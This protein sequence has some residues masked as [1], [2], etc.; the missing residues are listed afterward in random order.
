VTPRKKSKKSS[1]R[2]EPAAPQAAGS[3]SHSIPDPQAILAALEERGVPTS[4]AALAK[5]FNLRDDK[6][7]KGLTKQL[8]QM[9][10]R[11]QLLQNRRDEYCLLQK[12]DAITGKVSAH[13]DGFGFLIR[14]G[15]G[16]D[17]FLPPH[18]MS[19]I[20]DGDRVAVRLSGTDRKGRPKGELVEILERGK[21]TA[22][23]RFCSE[24]GVS[25]VVETTRAQ[26]HYLVAPVDT[27]G[28]KDGEMVKIEI[29]AYPTNRREAQGK[30]V[31]VLG[32]PDDPGMLT[33]MAIES[34]GLRTG[35]SKKTREAAD[36]WGAEVREAD[37]AGRVDLRKVP[38]VTIDGADAR[39]FD[40]AVYAEPASQ[41]KDK[42]W[43]LLVAIA[44]VSHYVQRDDA[45]DTEARKRGTSTYFPDRVVPMLPEKLSNGLC[46][47]N[48]DVD[49]L[50]LVCEMHVS[51]SGK[52]EKSKFFKGVMRSH[53]RLTYSQVNEV[54]GERDPQARKEHAAL[55]PQLEH[56]YELFK[57]FEKARS[58]RGALDLELPEVRITMGADNHSVE[59]VAPIHRN[60]AH[61]LI[62]ECMIAANVQAAKYLRKHKLPD[63]YRVH[64]QPGEERFEELRLML[65]E[66]GFKISAEARTQPRALNA[67]LHAL[68]DRP[69][70]PI[71]ATSVLRTFAQAVYQP[72]NEGHF[73]LALDAYA[74]FTSPIRRYP[75]LLVHRGITHILDGGKP[76][77]F[78][79]NLAAME[80]LG[81]DCSMLER[82]AEAA[83]RHVEARYKCI[84]MRDHVGGEY[85]GVVTGVTHFGLFVMLNDFFVE[86]LIHV[87]SLGNDYYHSEHGG[88]RLSG[89]R[90]GMSFG[91][92]DTLRVRVTRV[93]V[94]DAKI[95]L[96]LVGPPGSGADDG[97][98][99]K[100]RS[101]QPGKQIRKQGGDKGRGKTGGGKKSGRNR[102]GK[103]KAQRR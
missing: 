33:T 71:L 8:G 24:R 42:G 31:T 18:A 5:T 80:A 4:F 26:Q 103:K 22:V 66:L 100:T 11:G 13:R 40:D 84:Y 79:Y 41:D 39:D 58:R 7:R 95:D 97:A 72:L 101:R 63:L 6:A 62:E 68:R 10:T 9:L 99:Q 52:V 23:G 12:I 76:A 78:S 64:P 25:Y 43:T 75:D 77:A 28:A 15:E 83:A 91:L 86:G 20:M 65:Q 19:Q 34:F 27:G 44:D 54:V 94:E 57:A 47:L 51:T 85:E 3:Y 29:I 88:L 102:S 70:F 93:D 59:T 73:G 90:T 1:S 17:V 37:K 53:A 32:A 61:R 96:Q 2:P 49:R 45:L 46:S 92:G 87:T 60:D 21:A 48:P 30:V 14:D 55:L 81:K 89:E 98:D 67:V 69:D 56:L 74:H 82:Q 35:W 38:L 16:D 36:H 50:C